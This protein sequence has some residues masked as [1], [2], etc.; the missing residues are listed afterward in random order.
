MPVGKKNAIQTPEAQP[1]AQ[2]LP[3]RALATVDEEAILLVKQH[4]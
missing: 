3:L 2:Q 4:C 1:T